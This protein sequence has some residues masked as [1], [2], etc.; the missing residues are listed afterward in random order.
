GRGAVSDLKKG[1]FCYCGKR[2]ILRNTAHGGHELAC[3]SCGAPIHVM[4]P[5]PTERAKAAAGHAPTP[6][7]VPFRR[8]K[9]KKH[10]KKKTF[11]RRIASEILDEIEDIFD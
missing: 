1:T 7:P 10:K 6:N 3:G 5:L 11:W 8:K 4:K 9:T 2:T